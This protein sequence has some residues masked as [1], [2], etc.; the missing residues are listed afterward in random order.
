MAAERA[1]SHWPSFRTIHKSALNNPK[2]R[3]LSSSASPIYSHKPKTPLPQVAAS[4]ETVSD[5]ISDLVS[6]MQSRLGA[7]MQDQRLR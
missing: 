7:V 5:R 6:Q 2:T 4:S 1:S 3:F